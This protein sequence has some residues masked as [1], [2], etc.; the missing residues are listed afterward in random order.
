[1]K[2]LRKTNVVI[3]ILILGG[4]FTYNHIMKNLHK[5]HNMEMG[6]DS[7]M[8]AHESTHKDPINNNVSK[9]TKKLLI[10]PLMEGTVKNG[11]REFQL[12]SMEGEWDFI[13]GTK[14]KTYG[15]SSPI[16]S[17]TLLLNKDEETKITVTNSLEEATTVHWHGATVGEK[18]D[19]VHNSEIMPG[20]SKEISFKLNQPASTLWFHPH[21]HSK[22]ASQVYKGMAGFIYLQDETSQTLNL[23][24]TYGV[25]DI[26]LAVQEKKLDGENQIVVESNQMEK[27]HGKIGGYMMVNGIISPTLEVPKGI[28]RLR[29]LNG[30]NATKYDYS[31]EGKIFYQIASDGG[32]LEKPIS[33]TTLSL[34]PGERAEI[35]IDTSK[36]DIKFYMVVNDNKALE[37]ET[38]GIAAVKDIPTSLVKIEPITKEMLESVSSTRKFNLSTKGSKNLINDG[39]YDHNKIDF[40]VKKGTYEIWEISNSFGGMNM[41]HPFHVH[42]TQFRVIERNG[43]VP[44]ENENGWK[45]TINLNPKETVKILIKFENEGMSVYHCHILE[46]E[47]GGMMGQFEVIK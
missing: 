7:S 18:V 17:P 10:P 47:D 25:D 8:H 34:A 39:S 4:F 23:P 1:M 24:K 15:Y 2:I 38:K 32:L 3:G 27:T 19:G 26:P 36:I 16:L 21:T 11:V 44:S 29:L 9:F 40:S 5:G 37:I 12:T 22:T 20:T 31:F 28:I 14:T 45:D 35:L 42:G 33:M 46:H 41:P 30:S 43:K 13:S 6:N